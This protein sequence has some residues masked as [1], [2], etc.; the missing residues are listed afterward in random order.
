MLLPVIVTPASE[1]VVPVYDM[2]P[3]NILEWAKGVRVVGVRTHHYLDNKWMGEMLQSVVM[4][5]MLARGIVTPQRGRVVQG[6]TMVE[7]AERARGILRGGLS[8]ERLVWRVGE[9]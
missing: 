1:D 5:G 3:E 2:Q 7:R 6:E 8:G 4:P 9:E